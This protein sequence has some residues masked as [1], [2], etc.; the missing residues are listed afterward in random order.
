MDDVR[1][2]NARQV[3]HATMDPK[4]AA[5]RH[6]ELINEVWIGFI[7]VL[8][9]RETC[10]LAEE[11]EVANCCAETGGEICIPGIC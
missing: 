10:A 1:I 6:D 2:A 8:K 4:Y 7:D 9:V 11:M 5:L 3:I